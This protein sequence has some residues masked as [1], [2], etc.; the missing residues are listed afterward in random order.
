[1]SLVGNTQKYNRKNC[2]FFR[3][4]T[5]FNPQGA[6]ENGEGIRQTN[7]FVVYTLKYKNET[8]LNQLSVSKSVIG[9][10]YVT[11]LQAPPFS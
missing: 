3:E 6:V 5:I 9:C 4:L 11:C 8:G 1:M 2:F 7:V 10:N